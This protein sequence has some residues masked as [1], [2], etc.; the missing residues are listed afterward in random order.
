[1]LQLSGL[2]ALR[3]SASIQILAFCAA[4]A[5]RQRHPFSVVGF[6]TYNGVPVEFRLILKNNESALCRLLN[7][8]CDYLNKLRLNCPIFLGSNRT[9][10]NEHELTHMHAYTHTNTQP[11]VILFSV[12][13]K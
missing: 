12:C 10:M 7:L 1:M 2:R 8:R 4:T 3:I 6:F 9:K 11:M 13:D 5:I